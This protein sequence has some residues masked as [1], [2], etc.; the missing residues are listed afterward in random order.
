MGDSDSD[1]ELNNQRYIPPPMSPQGPGGQQHVQ[2]DSQL[3]QQL[4]DPPITLTART[5]DQY[6]NQKFREQMAAVTQPAPTEKIIV[7]SS[8]YQRR[9]DLLLD[10]ISATQKINGKNQEAV[11]TWVNDIHYA[12]D[13][14]G[15]N[16]QVVQVIAQTVLG[17]LR[18]EV[19][20]FISENIPE[21]GHRGSID[22][23]LIVEHVRKICLPPN[24]NR[25]R[26]QALETLRKR[27]DETLLAF[28]GRFRR[29]A[30]EAF[31][32]DLRTHDQQETLSS[33]YLRALGNDSIAKNICG[34]ELRSIEDTMR[35]ASREFEKA[36]RFDN[37]MKRGE[38]NE[39]AQQY[40]DEPMEIGAVRG[41]P[42]SFSV[43]KQS[44]HTHSQ[45][46]YNPLQ[47]QV[48]KMEKQME[49]ALTEIA[50]LKVGGG[51]H[52]PARRDKQRLKRYSKPGSWTPEGA[53][54]CYACQSPGHIARQCPL[55]KKQNAHKARREEPMVHAVGMYHSTPTP[56]VFC[57]PPRPPSHTWAAQGPNSYIQPQTVD[58]QANKFYQ[59]NHQPTETR[60][61]NGQ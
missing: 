50:K 7:Q 6:F 5:L 55:R 61:G 54:V 27:P 58:H 15:N 32:R 11:R 47:A 35:R 41:A 22:F 52:E 56:P 24:E 28:N 21:G 23:K 30:D 3:Q 46:P 29:I 36:Y 2:L 16:E 59:P 38:V 18:D 1:M 8:E 53:P 44:D 40:N 19:E 34:N 20:S 45:P 43:Q 10:A 14:L 42:R 33:A 9:R 17:S 60:Q 25:R 12:A 39:E 4:V 31:P 37:Y 26:R 51:D 48:S 57:G 49:R 13:N